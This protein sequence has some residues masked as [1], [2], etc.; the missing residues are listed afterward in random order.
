[1]DGEREGERERGRNGESWGG[2]GIRERW[3]MGRWMAKKRSDMRR[4]SG[5]RRELG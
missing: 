3:V 5:L 1:M 4:E 2:S